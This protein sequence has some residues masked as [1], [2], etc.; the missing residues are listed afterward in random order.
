MGDVYRAHDAVLGRDVAIKILPKPSVTM[1]N[2][3]RDSS[4]KPSSSHHS[5][6][7]TSPRF[8][9]CTSRTVCVVWCSNW[10][11]VKRSPS[12]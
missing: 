5:A 10:W 9:A 2:G 6:I 4:R 8:T 12:E 11:T 7:R 3:W 1:Q